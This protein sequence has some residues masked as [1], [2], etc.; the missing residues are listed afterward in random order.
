MASKFSRSIVHDSDLRALKTILKSWKISEVLQNFR[1]LFSF[2]SFFFKKN[3]Q[4]VCKNIIFR[5]GI[6]RFLHVYFWLRQQEYI[7]F[8]VFR[9]SVILT[10]DLWC[11]PVFF[12]CFFVQH[13][14]F[15]FQNEVNLRGSTGGTTSTIIVA[16]RAWQ[17]FFLVPV[18]K[19]LSKCKPRDNLNSFYPKSR[20]NGI[21]VKNDPMVIPENFPNS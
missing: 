16:V 3:T 4:F 9:T 15:F 2:L 20:Q 21:K 5:R 1:F 6:G 18:W 14:H 10:Y 17:I 19:Y 11:Y 7:F 12:W 8:A 13:F